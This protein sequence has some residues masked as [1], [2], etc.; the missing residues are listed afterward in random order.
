MYGFVNVKCEFAS[1]VLKVIKKIHP[2][3][4]GCAG[5]W[6][7]YNTVLSFLIDKDARS[8]M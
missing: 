7:V 4:L 2:N 8:R 3:L 1:D 5:T 6:Y